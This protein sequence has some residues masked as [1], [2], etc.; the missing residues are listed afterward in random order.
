MFLGEVIMAVITAQSSQYI[1]ALA[2]ELEIPEEHYRRAERSYQSF[3]KWTHRED[4]S[5]RAYSPRSAP[6]ELSNLIV[7]A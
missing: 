7:S 1:K 2:R 3:G 6:L 4:S 5:I